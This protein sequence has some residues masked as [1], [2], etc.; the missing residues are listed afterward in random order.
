MLMSVNRKRVSIFLLLCL[1]GHTLSFSCQRAAT[2]VYSQEEPSSILKYRISEAFVGG[3]QQAVSIVNPT[4]HKITGG[5]LFIPLITNETALH[6]ATLQNI[7]STI[8]QPA[9]FKDDSENTY[10]YWH[11][12]TVDSK[13]EI[14]IKMN[15]DVLS[16]STRFLV[17]ASRIL[18]YS[19]GSDLYQ[20]YTQPEEFVQA[21]SPAIVSAA[22]N[23]TENTNNVHE[24]AARIYDF[25]VKHVRYTAQD[26]E[27]G[28]LWA[29][30]NRTG[31]CSEHSY[32]FV[33]LCRAAGIPARIKTGFGFSLVGETTDNGHMWAEYYLEGY[34]WIPVD[35]TWKLFDS[36]D[37]RHFS[38]L[39]SISELMP[40]SNVFFNYTSGPDEQYVEQ[41]QSVSLKTSSPNAFDSFPIGNVTKTITRLKEARLIL[42]ITEIFSIQTLAVSTVETLQHSLDQS[43]IWLQ[44]VV[45]VFQADRQAAQSRAAM[46]ASNADEALGEALKLMI[47]MV[48]M[49][50]AAL[51]LT[52]LVA[53]VLLR[54]H[55]RTLNR[56][57]QARETFLRSFR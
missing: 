15:Y 52:V 22:Q 16:F 57:S 10:A 45:T 7:T 26:Y 13:T 27:R 31:D 4:A 30:E 49:F 20:R 1:I 17:N 23:I 6:Y 9:I 55:R 21:D 46:A 2:S 18:L 38:S 24:K 51:T 34:G 28:A 11:D 12:I 43:E 29:L 33:A 54:R 37:F 56:D 41:K 35:A 32:L 53:L 5:K 40:Y 48:A 50:V 44:E 25:V 19:N 3:L 39:Q 14:V 42:S 47:L 36:L 8:G